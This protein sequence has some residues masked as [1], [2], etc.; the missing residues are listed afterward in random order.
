MPVQTLCVETSLLLSL[1]GSQYIFN[2]EQR[3][4]LNAG[5]HSLVHD[6]LSPSYEQLLF[7]YCF[8]EMM[9]VERGHI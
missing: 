5:R 9:H 3:L 6:W 4:V 1:G 7:S 2:W 8:S